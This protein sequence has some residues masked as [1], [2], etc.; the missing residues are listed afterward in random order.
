M[1][2]IEDLINFF[3]GAPKAAPQAKPRAKY[4]NEMTPEEQQQSML[5][6]AAKHWLK[7]TGVT[8][9]DIG[10]KIPFEIG[11]YRADPTGKH[12]GKDGLETLPIKLNAPELYGKVRAMAVGAK[13][14][15][16]QLTP[17]QLAAIALKEGQGVSGV[18]GVDPVTVKGKDGKT[19]FMPYDPNMKGDKELFDKLIAEGL[20][21]QSAAFAVRLKNKD[22]TARRLKIPLASAW[23]GTGHSGYESSREYANAMRHF[24]KAAT[25]EKNQA[26]V[27]F[28]RSAMNLPKSKRAQALSNVVIDDGNPAKRRKLI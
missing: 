18:F 26:F 5:R 21:P 22:E 7:G 24:D 12:G 13:Y 16:P 6:D 3:R 15:V 2:G 8:D 1:A 10:T 28:I 4:W 20:S 14:G 17:E 9:T 11:G 25:H 19:E 27:E 23:V